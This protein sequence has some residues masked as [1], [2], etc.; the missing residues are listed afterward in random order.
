MNK[1]VHIQYQNA[2]TDD[3]A[4]LLLL[5]DLCFGK[6]KAYRKL[7]KRYFL[8]QIAHCIVAKLNDQPIG[9]VLTVFTP[10]M[11]TATIN[12]LC[13]HPRLRMQGIGESLLNWAEIEALQSGA[14]QIGAEVQFDNDA[15]T[16]L[17]RQ[18]GY[19][20]CSDVLVMIPEH[21]DGT[22]MRKR[23]MN[24]VY[25]LRHPV[26]SEEIELSALNADHFNILSR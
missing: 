13:V 16:H 15:M 8:S 11:K 1:I 21:S 14:T 18:S 20:E 6:K 10:N 17:L 22:K 19:D 23:L 3:L 7:L 5:E 26:A 2:T 4:D 25:D 24:G 9:Y 12:A